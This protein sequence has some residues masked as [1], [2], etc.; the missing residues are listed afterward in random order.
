MA[1]VGNR[2]TVAIAKEATPVPT[3]NG[4]KALRYKDVS[5]PYPPANS[6]D[7]KYLTSI[8]DPTR[9]V[10]GAAALGRIGRQSLPSLPAISAGNVMVPDR[11]C[12]TRRGG[13]ARAPAPHSN[14][15]P[16]PRPSTR[17]GVVPPC[18]VPRKPYF[19][20]TIIFVGREGMRGDH[21]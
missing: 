18:M 19:S 9:F 4:H 3:G 20:K 21:H 5:N 16:A 11:R 8:S 13:Q 10:C 17:G 14:G 12:A 1:V 7:R 2:Y 15:I 6:N